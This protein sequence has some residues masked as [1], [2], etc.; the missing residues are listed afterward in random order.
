[1]RTN[2]ILG[3]VH[4]DDARRKSAQR[5]PRGLSPQTIRAITNVYCTTFKNNIRSGI[6]QNFNRRW[7]YRRS[8]GTDLGAS[9]GKIAKSMLG[10]FG[11]R[12]LNVGMLLRRVIVQDRLVN[13]QF[14]LLK[15]GG[16]L[17]I[18]AT[19]S[20]ARIGI[21]IMRFVRETGDRRKGQHDASA[22]RI[23]GGESVVCPGQYFATTKMLTM[24]A[25]VVLQ[26]DMTRLDHP[27]SAHKSNLGIFFQQPD[28]DI[29][30]EICP[31]RRLQ[32]GGFHAEAG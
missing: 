9:D 3:T 26:F 2:T 20:S 24:S 22:F 8:H 28:Y 25:M 23:F 5:H 13:N 19:N 12:A 11:V 7:F 6:P 10:T 1:M 30:L 17:L 16:I 18:P 14:L 15:K 27:D 4:K 21:S 32:M 31:P 29:E